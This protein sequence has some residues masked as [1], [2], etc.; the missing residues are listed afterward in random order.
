M[1][2][3]QWDVAA[4]QEGSQHH[5]EEDEESLEERLAAVP[6]N[7]SRPLLGEDLLAVHVADKLLLIELYG[8]S[9]AGIFHRG[10]VP[11]QVR[12]PCR[13][14][15]EKIHLTHRQILSILKQQKWIKKDL[16]SSNCNI[17]VCLRS[18][19]TSLHQLYSELLGISSYFPVLQRGTI[20]I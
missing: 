5:L 2:Q 3:T 14:T 7:I 10:R 19:H 13:L 4:G 15:E 16:K 8:Q 9:Q 1:W 11:Q 18:I 17:A 6:E 12:G 20:N